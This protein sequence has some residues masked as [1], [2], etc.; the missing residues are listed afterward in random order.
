MT[1]SIGQTAHKGDFVAYYRVS[2]Q[3]QGQSGLGL[4]AQREAVA[5]Y[6][7]GGDW[8]LLA[9]FTE[10]ET[11]KGSNALAKRPQLQQAIAYSKKH[12]ATL[13]IAKLDR[14]ARNVHFVSSLMESKVDFLCCDMPS[15]T[16]LTIHIL[17]AVAEDEAKRISQRTKAALEQAKKN[18]VKLGNPQLAKTLN[19]PRIERA[20]EFAE[21]MRPILSALKASG[22]TQRVMVE[23]LNAK[24]IASARGGRWSLIQLQRT[25]KRLGL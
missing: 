9:E 10:V 3:K 8:Q 12:R 18:G 13:L 19:A 6:L 2:T 7:N 11:G 24:G 1:A 22:M 14:L 17:A 5:Q 21:S 4:Q 25:L 16:P 15:A 23:E 20:N